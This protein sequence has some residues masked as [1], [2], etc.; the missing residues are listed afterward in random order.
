MSSAVGSHHSL[1]NQ[2]TGLNRQPAAPSNPPAIEIVAAGFFRLIHEQTVILL[3]AIT[4]ADIPN[5]NHA[6]N[7]RKCIPISGI[8][9]AISIFLPN[10]R[11]LNRPGWDTGRAGV[12]DPATRQQLPVHRARAPVSAADT[13]TRASIQQDRVS[14]IGHYPQRQPA[15][16]LGPSGRQSGASVWGRDSR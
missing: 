14:S 9:R 7:Q 11:N 10:D 1:L 13:E 16:W 12:V 8:E 3:T 15:S 5:R 6:M 4:P 2:A